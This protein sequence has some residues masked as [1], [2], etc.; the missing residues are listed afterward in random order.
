MA[1]SG[2]TNPRLASQTSF[3]DRDAKD[4]VLDGGRE[5]CG[6]EGEIWVSRR[7]SHARHRRGRRFNLSLM[8]TAAGGGAAMRNDLRLTAMRQQDL[9]ATTGLS[10]PAVQRLLRPRAT[11]ELDGGRGPW[12]RVC[13][14]QLVTSGA[15]CA[16]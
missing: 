5:I 3:V 16:F 6:D 7:H 14:Q 12:L 2:R 4:R 9:G 1:V 11:V 8:R 10:T 13:W 15:A